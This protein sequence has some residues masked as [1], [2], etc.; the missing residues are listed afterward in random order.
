MIKEEIQDV[1]DNR[2]DKMRKTSLRPEL[3]INQ[4]I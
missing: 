1:K 3:K 2:T 4:K